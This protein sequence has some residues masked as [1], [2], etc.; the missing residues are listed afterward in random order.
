MLASHLCLPFGTGLFSLGFLTIQSVLEDPPI[1]LSLILSLETYLVRGSSH[2]VAHYA[3]FFSLLLLPPS[4]VQY[5][6]QHP[7]LS[8]K[9]SDFFSVR[10]K[11]SHI[12]NSSK[13]I[14][15]CSTNYVFIQ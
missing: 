1:P 15:P 9:A 11:I 14:V 7:V 10:D 6:F 5:I 13:I 2:E 3:V 12:R 4:Q 8:S